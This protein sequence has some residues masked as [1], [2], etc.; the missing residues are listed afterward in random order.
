MS[1][2]QPFFAMR[3]LNFALVLILLGCCLMACKDT[4]E[5]VTET[6]EYGNTVTYNRDKE[7]YGREGLYRVTSPDGTRMEEA[8][9][10]ANTLSGLRI[11][12]HE[13][14]DT[15]IVETYVGDAFDGPYRV[16]GENGQLRQVG[17]YAKNEM[18]G[19]WRTFYANGQLKEAV[20]F[21]NNQENGPFIEYHENGNLAAEG[22]YLDGDH[23]HGELKVYDENGELQRRMECERGRCTTV[24]RAE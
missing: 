3:L 2:S 21:A 8:Q 12:Y 11:L 17:Q 18:T 23:E 22:Q 1:R 16:Y 14:G 6:D 4:T 19:E 13:N 7:T 5:A 10:V 15:N 20:Q 9:Y 24:W